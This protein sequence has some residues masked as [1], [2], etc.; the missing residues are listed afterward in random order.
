MLS[1]KQIAYC[2]DFWAKKLP[3]LD[4]EKVLSFRKEFTKKLISKRDFIGAVAVDVIPLS[5][6]REALKD[7]KLPFDAIKGKIDMMFNDDDT[8]DVWEKGIWKR[9]KL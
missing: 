1:K 2:V 5:E 9:I 8:I 3:D 7:A 4:K 6:I